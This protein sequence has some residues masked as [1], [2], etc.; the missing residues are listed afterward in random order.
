M[1][2]RVLDERPPT[3]QYAVVLKPRST[4]QQLLDLLH[5]E[6]LPSEDGVYV[7]PSFWPKGS[8]LQPESVLPPVLNEYIASVDP[9][10]RLLDFNSCG[11]QETKEAPQEYGGNFQEA[12]TGLQSLFWLL[13]VCI[14][15]RVLFQMD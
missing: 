2:V 15:V 8:G 13:L 12:I 5:K 7:R 14:A 6:G 9:G 3:T 10:A 1:L 11:E 4:A